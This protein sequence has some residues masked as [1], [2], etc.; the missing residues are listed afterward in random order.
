M[1]RNP[2]GVSGRPVVGPFATRNNADASLSGRSVSKD[3]F[4]TA[5]TSRSTGDHLPPMSTSVTANASTSHE[6]SPQ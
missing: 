2:A 1:V 3:A 5:A 4:S 6:R